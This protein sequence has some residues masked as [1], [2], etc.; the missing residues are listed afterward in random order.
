M[1]TFSPRTTMWFA[2]ITA[3]CQ[4]IA[5]SSIHLTN[6]IPSDWIPTVTAWAAAIATANITLI[7]IMAGMSSAGRGPLAGPPS[8]TEAHQVMTEAK[9]AVD[10]K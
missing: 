9:A 5:G 6:M 1:P 7:G 3:I 8:L 4:A 2:F 10:Q